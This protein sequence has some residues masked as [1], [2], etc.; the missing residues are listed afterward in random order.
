MKKSK[1]D[2]INCNKQKNKLLK[3]WIEK[4]ILTIK[5]IKSNIMLMYFGAEGNQNQ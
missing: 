3:K 4:T 2:N 1:K 5:I